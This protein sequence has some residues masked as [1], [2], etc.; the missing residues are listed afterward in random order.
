MA[1]EDW[2]SYF[3]LLQKLTE[4]L[5]KLAQMQEEKKVC[6]EKGK[7]PRLEE[8]MKEEQVHAMT[9]RGLEQ[10]RVVVLKT[11][12]VPQGKLADLE[13]SMP[14]DVR[15]QGKKVVAALQTQYSRYR[16]L[17]DISKETLEFH[18]NQIESRTGIP[19]GYEKPMANPRE[20]SLEKEGVF[21]KGASGNV[22]LNLRQFQRPQEEN[23]PKVVPVSQA[24]LGRVQQA[25]D[26]DV[27][28]VKGENFSVQIGGGGNISDL[29]LLAQQEE[30]NRLSSVRKKTM[31]ANAQ[32]GDKGSSPQ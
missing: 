18:L 23:P 16:E 24:Q 9:L 15:G 13:K 11:L 29:R 26:G 19:S 4:T 32:L 5:E 21:N 31:Q 10:K 2:L 3:G 27:L 7:L 12:D 14:L 8:I 20:R 22:P 25:Q 1:K 17:A 6:V 28:P 30:K